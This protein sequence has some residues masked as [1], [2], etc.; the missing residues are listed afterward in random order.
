MFCHYMNAEDASDDVKR[1]LKKWEG[2]TSG[3]NGEAD[4]FGWM[5][6]PETMPGEKYTLKDY[7]HNGQYCAT[8]LAYHA[9][10]G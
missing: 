7:L 3:E 9:A 8:G 1:C 2:L 4:T 6:S 10:E 5:V